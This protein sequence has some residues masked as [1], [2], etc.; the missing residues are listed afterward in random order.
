MMYG[1]KYGD[2]GWDMMGG[3]GLIH[4]TLWLVALVDLILVGVWLWKQ[5]SK[6]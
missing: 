3:V 4:F 1:Y 2:V 6:K 5:I